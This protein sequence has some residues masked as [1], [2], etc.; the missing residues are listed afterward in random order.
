MDLL[1]L[2]KVQQLY[3]IT[4]IIC[5]IICIGEAILFLFSED[6]KE[7]D[8]NS[9]DI[10]IIDPNGH[11]GLVKL[12]ILMIFVFIIIIYSIWHLKIDFSYLYTPMLI[13]AFYLII[14]KPFI[15]T[16]S[17]N[18]EYTSYSVFCY[19]FCYILQNIKYDSIINCFSNKLFVESFLLL[20]LLIKIY[21]FLFSIIINIRYFLKLI[22][23][24]F[25]IKKI[26]YTLSEKLRINYN[27]SFKYRKLKGIKK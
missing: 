22:K 23:S 13:M 7:N 18:L 11:V 6:K 17:E 16:K 1:N 25:K 21:I 15:S 9:E 5:M 8:E 10:P 26:H 2:I 20:V 14:I 3:N 24:V 19:W 27:I 4:S 12:I